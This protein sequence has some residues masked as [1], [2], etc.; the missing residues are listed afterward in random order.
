MLCILRILARP[1]WELLQI[2]IPRQAP[3]RRA[4][5][6]LQSGGPARGVEHPGTGDFGRRRTFSG[7]NPLKRGTNQ[8]FIAAPGYCSERRAKNRSMPNIP[9]MV[10]THYSAGCPGQP[11]SPC[12]SPWEN[13]KQSKCKILPYRVR[14]EISSLPN[15]LPALFKVEASARIPAL[16]HFGKEGVIRRFLVHMRS[17][18]R[19]LAASVR[20]GYA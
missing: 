10:A 4:G 5:L 20:E 12:S 6:L 3:V 13:R 7:S 15:L 11:P 19:S 9:V 14:S 16:I 18:S 1:L 17:L 8:V 2:H